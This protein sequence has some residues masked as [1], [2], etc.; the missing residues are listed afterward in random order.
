MERVKTALLFLLVIGSLV[1]SYLLVFGN[2]RFE[3]INRVGYVQTEPQ[4]EPLGLEDV[5][6]PAEIVVHHGDGRH[7]VVSPSFPLSSMIYD[8]VWAFMRQRTFDGFRRNALFV[9]PFE[10]E[11]MRNA[12]KGVEVRFPGGVPPAVLSQLLRLKG[13]VPPDG[14]PVGRIWI[15]ESDAAGDVRVLFWGED[16]FPLYEAVRADVSRDDLER[17]S[18]MAAAETTYRFLTG[19]FYIPDVS[20]TVSVWRAP[21]RKYTAEQLQKNLF[22]DL[23]NTRH[24][25]EPNGSEI[26]TDGT[27]VIQMR[28]DRDWFAYSDPMP[29]SDRPND[30]MENLRAVLGFGNQHGLW[31]GGYVVKT[32]GLSNAPGRQSLTFGLIFQRLAVVP[33][34]AESF[35]RIQ[36]VVQNGIVTRFERSVL[37]VSENEARP[38]AGGLAVELP[39]GDELA[40]FLDRLPERGE[41]RAVYPA[42]RPAADEREVRFI[43]VWAVELQNGGVRLLDGRPREGASGWTG[44]APKPY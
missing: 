13:D 39:G 11:T 43:P 31:N 42:F 34:T 23:Q 14:A 19:D 25:A 44:G 17:F 3:P 9:G 1:Q 26:Y 12:R 20:L 5:V 36:A 27:R 37:Y 40:A 2:P 4:G 28:P 15:Y 38:D 16:G 30:V 18:A 35:G 22:I 33:E 29:D 21:Y 41:I 7:T 8:S 6:A 32:F 10:R 24:I